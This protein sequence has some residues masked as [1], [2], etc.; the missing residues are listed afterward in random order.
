VDDVFIEDGL[1][2]IG[3]DLKSI[4]LK[5]NDLNVRLQI[6][7]TAGQEQFSSMTRQYYRGC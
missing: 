7:D 5:V 1:S 3:M 2:T 6:W 4:T